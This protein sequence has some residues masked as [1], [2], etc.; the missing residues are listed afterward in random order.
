MPRDF[1]QPSADPLLLYPFRFRNPLTG[2]WHRARYVAALSEIAMRH[3]DWQIAGPPEIREVNPHK[4]HFSPHDALVPRAHLP[5]GEPPQSDPPRP[6]KEPP[7]KDPPV[8]EPPAND[9]PVKEPPV[10]EPSAI[11]GLERFLLLVFLRRYVTY[12]ARRRRFGAMNG[13]AR[14]FAE[15]SHPRGA[16]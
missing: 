13:A 1:L 7:S 6:E 5:A 16:V 10:E 11:S 12:C 15:L 8:K 4:R 14:L 2:K 9:P 3:V